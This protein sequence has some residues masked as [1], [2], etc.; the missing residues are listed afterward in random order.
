M[1]GH[2]RFGSREGGVEVVVT[3]LARRMA[4]LG[5]EV[6]CYD[7][8]GSDVMTGEAT[9]LSERI[10][11]G[12]RIVPVKTIDKKGLAAL[13]SS[14]FA[15]RQAIKD[16]PD[17]IHYHAEGPCVPLPLA[18]RAGI[19]TVATIHGLDWQRAKWGRLAS[20]CIK[21][22]EK[23]AATQSNELIV[24]SSSAEGYFKQEYGR[25]A[26][27]IHNGVEIRERIDASLIAERWGLSRGDYI[28]Y[29]GRLVPEK[30]GDLL[31]DAFRRLDTDKR[32]VIAGGGSD[33]DL[34]LSLESGLVLTRALFLPDS[35]RVTFS[36]SSI[37][38][39]M[40]TCSLPM[41]KVCHFLLW[42]PCPTVHVALRAMCPN[43]LTFLEAPAQ[44]LPKATFLSLL[45][46]FTAFWIIRKGP[47]SS[48]RVLASA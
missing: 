3:E 27:L 32:L 5:H 21:M 17:V 22:G 40:S 26:T 6:T 48:A 10:A 11:D 18:R 46:S 14:Y 19:R 24:L 38:M 8:S 16:R 42:K 15:T 41:W 20:T 29:L 2:K 7:R 4:A 9:S 23:A 43:A 37:R 45:A 39:H 30:R 28:L 33:T 47:T 13:S 12:V 31:V 36:P 35:S 25:E 34:R 1:I 44:L